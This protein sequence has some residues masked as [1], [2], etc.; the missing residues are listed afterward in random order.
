MAES[1][2]LAQTDLEMFCRLGI[3]LDLLEA[4]GVCRVTDAQARELGLRFAPASDLRGIIFPY[5]D[6]LTGRRLTARLR[7]DPPE[8]GSNGKPQNKYLS[9]Y[10][11]GRHLYFP[12]GAGPLLADLS[13]PVVFVEAEKSS[14]A[15]TALAARSGRRILAVA[16]GGCWSWRGKVGIRTTP[17][18]GRE[19]ERGPLPDL[20][21]VTWAQ[22]RTAIIAFDSDSQ[23]NAAVRAA[24]WLFAQCLA[25][26]GAKVLFADIPDEGGANGP[27]DLI[28]IAGDQGML[29]LL[30]AGRPFA[31]QAEQDAQAAVTGLDKSRDLESRDSAL[32]AIARVADHFHVR[33][34]AGRAAKLLEEPK[35]VVEREVGLRAKALREA[36]ESAKEAVRRGRLLRIEVE[37]TTL[38]E[39]LE[40]FFRE[41]LGLP[42]GA[43]LILALFALNTYVFDV[44]D[45]TPYIQ[46]D[47]ALGGCGKTTLLLHLE[48]VCCHAYLGCDPT[49]AVLFRRIDRD[50]PTWL[51]DEASVV[52]GH[53]ERARMIRAVLDA[54]YRKG[55]TVSRCEGENNELR[56]FGVYCP[57]VFALVG[58]L[59][60]TL[61]DRCIVLHLQKTRGL[62]K[63]KLKRLRRDVLPLREKLEAYAA[64]Y[65]A[66]LQSLDDAEPDEGYWPELDGREEELWG[67]LLFHAKL[68]GPETENCA[69]AVALSFSR[70]K[71]QLAVAEDQTAALA[72]ELLEVLGE[73]SGDTFS[74][75]ELRI[76]LARKEAWGQKFAK[77][78]SEKAEECVI[79]SFLGNFRLPSRIREKSGTRYKLTEAVTVIG[80]H[81]P[82]VGAA[83]AT[84][85]AKTRGS[86]VASPESELATGHATESPKP[87]AVATAGATVASA[88]EGVATE[89]SRMNAE[90]VA[91]GNSSKGGRQAIL[92]F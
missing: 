5:L 83:H 10:G 76:A 42:N 11:D 91:S 47:S 51:L 23:T 65:R 70:Q 90:P 39:E 77:C 58:S 78:K 74:P 45:T 37:P 32:D 30:G 50:R 56:D 87:V 86:E 79:G 24:R 44:F 40:A 64:Q 73:M 82:Q 3:N 52:T 88:D 36:R 27:D 49:E 25:E 84:E 54:G 92:K 17:A 61:L 22:Q 62:P 38:I 18:G 2:A 6:P 48:V 28:E 12:P 20:S 53:E 43:T 16:T 31:A 14:L 19:E 8:V 29:D 60:G 80:Q 26:L 63:T 13:V 41:R 21:L 57:K 68:A 34:L 46:I 59:K 81:L 15:L 35:G 71:G 67:P 7:R 1:L 85:P 9:P 33:V 66:Q 72:T 55:A 75:G 4:A 89:E 69:L